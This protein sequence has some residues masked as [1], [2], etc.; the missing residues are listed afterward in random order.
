METWLAVLL[1][2][3]A[4]YIAI[5][6]WAAH[7]ESERFTLM[8]P[9]LMLR[10][11]AGKRTIDRMA[12]NRVWGVAADVFIAL[13]VISAL[14]MVFLL[15]WQNTLFFT[16]TE[17][18]GGDPPDLQDALAIPGVNPVIPV[19][20]GL[21]ALIVALVIH[22]GGHGILCRFANLNVKSLG[23]L[24]FIVPIGAFVEPDEEALQGATLREKLRMF[25]SGPGP[26]IVLGLACVFLFSQVMV[27]ALAPA[28]S[29]VALLNVNEGMPAAQAGLE[30][31]M[32]VTNIS[33]EE[34][35][36]IEG[37]QAALNVTY[38][39]AA[40]SWN[41][42]AGPASENA[43]QEG[44]RVLLEVEYVHRGEM[45]SV[46]VEPVDRYV[47]YEENAPQAN[48][49]SF[50]NKPFLGVSPADE[51]RL[52]GIMD[53]LESPFEEQGARGA[54]FYVAL[55]FV[56]M[57]PF[58][59]AFH[60][61]FVTTGL[62]E[63]WG[64]MFWVTANTL[65]WLFWLNIILGTFNAIP[66][67]PL[68][69]GHMLRHSLHAWFRKRR[70]IREDDLRV[71]AREDMSPTYVGRTPYVQD[72][73]DDVDGSVKLWNRLIGFS[74]LFLLLTPFVVPHFL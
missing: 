39:N 47:W 36:T 61:M 50:K 57:Q 71:L 55:P 62:F 48:Q 51:D 74:L 17:V 43:S 24:F 23:L 10:T 18:V 72:Q 7:K 53:N 4:F 60:D 16:H 1:G 11:Q 32:F 12:K 45:G 28:H 67:G 40:W 33:G 35:D 59:S 49:E 56:N 31:G 52:Q 58:P 66:M 41:H 8:G 22:E 29:G 14:L 44:E 68:D 13:T 26:N 65:Y 5:L 38:P 20:Y 15:V 3:T 46:Q 19:G 30:P 69:G 21:F 34:V 63:G 42:Q 54:L 70:G 73:L 25:S 64:D 27:P 37:F 6:L 2:L 9:L